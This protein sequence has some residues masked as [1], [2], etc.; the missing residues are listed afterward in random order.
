MISYRQADLLDSIKP[1]LTFQKEQV[2]IP[3]LAYVSI[4][5]FR[6]S[7]SKV[8]GVPA[9]QINPDLHLFLEFAKEDGK[10]LGYSWT[11]LIQHLWKHGYEPE[12][13]VLSKDNEEATIKLRPKNNS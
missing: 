8:S 7:L 11:D 6:Y 4:V 13:P 9:K 2:R 3:D 12:A 1:I 10:Y 5:K